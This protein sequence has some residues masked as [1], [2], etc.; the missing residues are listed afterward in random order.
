MVSNHVQDEV[1]LMIKPGFTQLKW[2]LSAL[3]ATA[4]TLFVLTL[5]G[6]R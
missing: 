4:A 5:E 1:T 6:H 3:S 2:A